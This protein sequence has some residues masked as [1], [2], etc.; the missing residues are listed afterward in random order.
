MLPVRLS[1]PFMGLDHRRNL[2]FA[3][4]ER[5]SDFLEGI[6]QTIISKN[7]V[8]FTAG[9]YEPNVKCDNNNFVVLIR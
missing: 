2:K 1:L 4:N 3:P 5:H 7:R 8:T 6:I 9:E